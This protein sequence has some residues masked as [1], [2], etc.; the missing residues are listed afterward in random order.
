MWTCRIGWSRGLD[1]SAA[2]RIPLINTQ[3]GGGPTPWPDRARDHPRYSARCW[4]AQPL[5]LR[6]RRPRGGRLG[7]TTDASTGLCRPGADR[8]DHRRPATLGA[9]G[10][11]WWAAASSRADAMPQPGSG[12]LGRPRAACRPADRR[13]GHA[14]EGGRRPRPG[15][16]RQAALQVE[17]AA[18]DLQLRHRPAA[19]VDLDRMHLWA[20][21]LQV[22]AATKDQGAVADE[23]AILQL[24]WDAPATPSTPP[25]PP[26]PSGS[27]PR[28][29][30]LAR[31]RTRRDLRRQLR[32]SRPF[33]LRCRPEGTRTYP[34]WI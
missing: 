34:A 9:A 10:A 4:V 21:R 33:E 14:D 8:P 1:G 26:P 3:T 6:R 32:G 5:P 23:A 13:P 15:R 18:L 17:Q 7:R 20:R 24:L 29:G 19:G 27:A 31:R 11:R 16:A 30:P 12:S 22:D 28:C 2:R 25:T